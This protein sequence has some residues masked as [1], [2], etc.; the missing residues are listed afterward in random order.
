V[1]FPSFLARPLSHWVGTSDPELGDSG[2]Q[3]ILQRAE[4][5]EPAVQLLTLGPATHLAKT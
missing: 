3:P 1:H 5:V 2:F 4:L